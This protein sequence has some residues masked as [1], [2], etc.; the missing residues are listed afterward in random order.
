[1][2]EQLAFL[3]TVDTG[4]LDLEITRRERA[5][6]VIVT[7]GLFQFH[8]PVAEL[9]LIIATIGQVITAD[10]R[11]KPG[12]AAAIE[13]GD[14]FLGV[15]L[16]NDGNSVWLNCAPF[17][18]RISVGVA[19]QFIAALSRARRQANEETA[20]AFLASRMKAAS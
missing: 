2:I 16:S 9:H 20:G 13:I 17:H 14:H 5:D 7:A 12:E 10:G 4:D 8:L 15:G 1:M 18:L 3:A 19:H 6:T 11:V